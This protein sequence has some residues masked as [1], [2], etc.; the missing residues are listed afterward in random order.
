MLFN[1]NSVTRSD[2]CINIHYVVLHFI[3]I[4]IHCSHSRSLQKLLRLLSHVVLLM[5]VKSIKDAAL[6]FTLHDLHHLFSISSP[7]SLNHSLKW[8]L[9]LYTKLCNRPHSYY[10]PALFLHWNFS[11][12]FL[13]LT[14]ILYNNATLTAYPY[15]RNIQHRRA[16]V[17]TR[18]K[19]TEYTGAK[20][21]HWNWQMITFTYER[22]RWD[23][24]WFYTKYMMI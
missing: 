17:L 6:H 3:I 11:L 14:T 23:V 20:Q 19:Y 18:I 12:S 8:P 1:S 9:V 2:T 22:W 5:N 15:P 16:T 24:D 10:F 4:H 7:I 21:L 13:T